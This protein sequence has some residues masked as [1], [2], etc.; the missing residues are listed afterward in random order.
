[1]VLK[2]QPYRSGMTKDIAQLSASALQSLTP[3]AAMN[4]PAKECLR[5][6]HNKIISDREGDL[7]AGPCLSPE[8]TL[9][10]DKLTGLGD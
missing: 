2:V 10:N 7:P 4:S 5:K 1:M 6:V 8:R 3:V 9:H